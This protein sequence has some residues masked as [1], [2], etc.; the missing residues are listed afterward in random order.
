MTRTLSSHDADLSRYERSTGAVT[1]RARTR[2][3][4]PHIGRLRFS[5]VSVI[6]GRRQPVDR[7]GRSRTPRFCPHP[8]G[9]RQPWATP[10]LPSPTARNGRLRRHGR[11]RGLLS[12]PSENAGS[13]WRKTSCGSTPGAGRT[14]GLVRAFRLGCQRLRAACRVGGHPDA[15]A[16]ISFIGSYHGN[17]SG[18]DERG[19]DTRR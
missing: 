12:F 5:P 13:H 18:F 14:A 9:A 6:G 7:G 2:R 11:A 10:T 4:S 17:L 15:P 16:F 19:A 8:G 3:S 1:I